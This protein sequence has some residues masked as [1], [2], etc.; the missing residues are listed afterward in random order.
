MADQPMIFRCSRRRSP[1]WCVLLPARLSA[2]TCLFTPR[3]Q[4]DVFQFPAFYQY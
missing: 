4:Q 3:F 1:G 2:A